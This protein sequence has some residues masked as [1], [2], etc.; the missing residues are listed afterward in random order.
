MIFLQ[1]CSSKIAR[2]IL[3]MY[4]FLMEILGYL[5]TNLKQA[6]DENDF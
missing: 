5:T 1:V 2:N 3:I 4:W 6:M